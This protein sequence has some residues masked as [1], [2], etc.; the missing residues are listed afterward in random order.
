MQALGFWRAFSEDQQ[1]PVGGG[2]GRL[3]RFGKQ[4]VD[5]KL[6]RKR[7]QATFTALSAFLP[8]AKR[9]RKVACPLFLSGRTWVA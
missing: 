1:F 5:F 4:P 8:P 6:Q 7:G 2:V 3:V 9:F